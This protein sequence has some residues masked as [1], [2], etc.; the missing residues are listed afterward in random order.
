[1]VRGRRKEKPQKSRR[2]WGRVRE[3]RDRIG[4]RK[5]LYFTFYG[6]FG[7]SVRVGIGEKNELEKKFDVC[8]LGGIK[9]KRISP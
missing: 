3:L 6:S 2:R 4:I 8:G 5:H 9:F 7:V 1:M